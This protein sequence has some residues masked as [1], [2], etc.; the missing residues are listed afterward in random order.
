MKK[1]LA[2]LLGALI[3]TGALAQSAANPFARPGSG[4]T[5]PASQGAGAP[6]TQGNAAIPP[7]PVPMN[8]GQPQLPQPGNMGQ[9]PGMTGV[10]PQ[11]YPMPTGPDGMPMSPSAPSAIE[12][13]VPVTRLGTVN[14]QVIYRGTGVYLFE[15]EGKQKLVRKPSLRTEPSAGLPPPVPGAPSSTANLPSMVGR[16]AP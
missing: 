16:P 6:P 5:A 10:P 13:E 9:P 1:L 12:Q 7:I 4:S 3:A 14:G 2:S 8:P 15:K 11:G